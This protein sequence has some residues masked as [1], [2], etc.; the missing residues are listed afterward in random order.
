MALTQLDLVDRATLPPD[1]RPEGPRCLTGISF[2]A[3]KGIKSV[4]IFHII[5]NLL[6]TVLPCHYTSHAAEK[7]PLQAHVGFPHSAVCSNNVSGARPRPPSQR[8][9]TQ[10]SS[11]Y[12]DLTCESRTNDVGRSALG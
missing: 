2:V 3:R 11:D 8:P 10:D 12:R 9:V 4:R 7:A 6:A 5:Y 1:R